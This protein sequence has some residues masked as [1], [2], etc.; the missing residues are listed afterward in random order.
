MEEQ[1]KDMLCFAETRDLR[2]KKGLPLWI[3]LEEM[4]AG[5][6]GLM[7]K[8]ICVTLAHQAHLARQK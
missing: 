7:V 8:I 6:G 3:I 2:I 4:A 5:W 1:T